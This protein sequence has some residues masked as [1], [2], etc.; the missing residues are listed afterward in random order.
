MPILSLWTRRTDPFS[1]ATFSG[2]TE[3]VCCIT[4]HPMDAQEQLPTAIRCQLLCGCSWLTE[5]ALQ[6]H[7]RS[8]L[9][10]RLWGPPSL[11]AA[12][13]E[14]ELWEN[15]GVSYV[16]PVKCMQGKS[17]FLLKQAMYLLTAKDCA[18]DASAPFLSPSSHAKSFILSSN[19]KIP[20]KWTQSPP[21]LKK[22]QNTPRMWMM[23]FLTYHN[24]SLSVLPMLQIWAL[25]H[26]KSS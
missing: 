10:I 22:E 9:S 11:V 25:L 1:A 26:F 15:G 4:W 18:W 21:R 17:Y 5:M 14:W 6:A 19:A 7:Q 16:L 24:M 8:V 3:I 13:I 23:G 12:W 2:Q 20:R